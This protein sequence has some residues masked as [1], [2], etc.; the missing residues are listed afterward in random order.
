MLWRI[1][2]I[3]MWC[4][5]ERSHPNAVEVGRAARPTISVVFELSQ[6]ARASLSCRLQHDGD[7]KGQVTH[8]RWLY[9]ELKLPGGA[10][11]PRCE[12]D[13]V[14]ALARSLIPTLTE[15]DLV[16]VEKARIEEA[17]ELVTPMVDALVGD[18]ALRLIFDNHD[19]EE[20]GAELEAYKQASAIFQASVAQRRK[21]HAD[22]APRPAP[23]AAVPL[24]AAPD[25]AAP[26]PP[27]AIPVDRDCTRADAKK[28][29]PPRCTLKKDEKFY[30]RWSV[31]APW[32][33][34][35]VTKCWGG[36][37]GLRCN[38]ALVF[39]LQRVWAV[40]L[41]KEPGQECPWDLGALF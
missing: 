4:L 5:C 25:P 7:S 16:G 30:T 24:A 13:F 9:A 39:C 6:R 21:L 14:R 22:R 38:Q 32:L 26:K 28:L 10:A 12:A 31:N 37:T 18:D 8:L 35:M 1:L 34:P 41:A 36:G 29:F 11:R 27:L 33:N 19:A 15:E 3:G 40:Y 20:H 23:Y 17:D 2:K